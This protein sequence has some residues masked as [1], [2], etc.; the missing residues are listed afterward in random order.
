MTYGYRLILRLH[1]PM[2]SGGRTRSRS[3]QDLCDRLMGGEIANIR[4][5]AT[6]PADTLAHIT[7]L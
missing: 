2:I 4:A 7:H 3:R 5:T 6:G 1:A